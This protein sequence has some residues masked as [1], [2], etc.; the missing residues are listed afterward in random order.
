MPVLPLPF[1]NPWLTL[2]TFAT[3]ISLQSLES[4]SDPQLTK[5]RQENVNIY[6]HRSHSSPTK[7]GI[8]SPGIQG[9]RD[10]NIIAESRNH[11]ECD[12]RSISSEEW[13]KRVKQSKD[14]SSKQIIIG[15][16]DYDPAKL[17]TLKEEQWEFLEMK[18]AAGLRGVPRENFKPSVLAM[19]QET[20]NTRTPF[21]VL[22]GGWGHSCIEPCIVY[23][24][25]SQ[26]VQI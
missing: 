6:R 18:A 26:K 9:N 3:G 2:V 7:D 4:E 15:V 21:C 25:V 22:N 20:D 17:N 19:D 16:S 13:L 5:S 8:L 11:H 12:P 24:S 10:S 1:A 23:Y 14:D